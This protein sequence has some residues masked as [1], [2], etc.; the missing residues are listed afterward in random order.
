MTFGRG[1]VSQPFVHMSEA[2]PSPGL[3]S[4]RRSIF[5]DRR[6]SRDVNLDLQFT[7][8]S[9]SMVWGS[10]PRWSMGPN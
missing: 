9:T 4:D 1:W 3:I 7:I 5:Q 2:V 8:N 6:F 10:N